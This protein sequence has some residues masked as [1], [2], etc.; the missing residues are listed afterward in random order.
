MK[1]ETFLIGLVIVI[2]LLFLCYFTWFIAQKNCVKTIQGVHTIIYHDTLWTLN[3]C[4]LSKNVPLK[5]DTT[6]V[7]RK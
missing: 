7:K 5:I 4:D 6:K 1:F 3:F 2:C